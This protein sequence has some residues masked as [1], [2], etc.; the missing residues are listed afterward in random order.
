[1]RSLHIHLYNRP[2]MFKLIPSNQT[3]KNNE[4]LGIEIQ[5]DLIFELC[6]IFAALYYW[7]Y[8]NVQM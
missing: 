4:R 8:N 1:M 5:G 7:V 3:V 2:M 6:R